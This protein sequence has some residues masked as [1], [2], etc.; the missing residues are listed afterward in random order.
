MFC[1]H[2]SNLIYSWTHHIHMFFGVFFP[3][4]SCVCSL[5]YISS[6]L[7]H[8]GPLCK[9]TCCFCLSFRRRRPIQRLSPCRDYLQNGVSL[10]VSTSHLLLSSSVFHDVES[11]AST[12]F[13][14]TCAIKGFLR[15]VDLIN[16]LLSPSLCCQP[17][18]KHS[19]PIR[20]N[21]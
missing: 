6:F 14:P 17:I 18:G 15:F 9:T 2:H 13:L 21:L 4:H 16:C 10:T 19:D 5:P 11:I 8:C 7:F 1:C 3:S 20:I 12:A